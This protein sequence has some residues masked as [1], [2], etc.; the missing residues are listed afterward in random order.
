[1]TGCFA[2][3]AEVLGR[4]HQAHAKNH[5]PIPIHGNARGERI[6]VIDEPR[7]QTKSVIRG[8]LR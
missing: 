4:F 1:M 3:N 8:T 6:V 5:L 2:L 7:R